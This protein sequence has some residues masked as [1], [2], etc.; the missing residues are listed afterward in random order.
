MT[1]AVAT[2]QE[3]L[4]AA[5]E[6]FAV[7]CSLFGV[8]FKQALERLAL[9]AESRVVANGAAGRLLHDV[10]HHVSFGTFNF[11]GLRLWHNHRHTFGNNN[12]LS[13]GNIRLMYHRLLNE[14]MQRGSIEAL[15]QNWSILLQ[16]GID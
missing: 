7:D 16:L 2:L 10:I 12:L 6:G 14:L 9:V 8:Q 1:S 13:A 15:I 3:C 5:R 11:D 4:L